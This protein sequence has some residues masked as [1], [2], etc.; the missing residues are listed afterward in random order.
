VIEEFRFNYT[1]RV[2]YSEIDGQMIVFNSVY[3]VYFDVALTEYLRQLGLIFS[4]NTDEPQFDYTLVKTTIRFHSPAFFDEILK[5]YVKI[6]DIGTTSF[7]T[8]FV[9]KKQE[10]GETIVTA[11]TVYVGYDANRRKKIPV[12]DHVRNSIERFESSGSTD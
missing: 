10:S 7:T 6:S 5:V 3:L 2:R 4:V 11:E 1:L 12:P 9:V 8:S